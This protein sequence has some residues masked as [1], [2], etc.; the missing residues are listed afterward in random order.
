[1]L[2]N[3]HFIYTLRRVMLFVFSLD[4][5]QTASSDLFFFQKHFLDN[6]AL[7]HFSSCESSFHNHKKKTCIYFMLDCVDNLQE[8]EEDV[9][10]V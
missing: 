3:F 9:L 4:K 8:E 6:Y 1:M 5:R 10:A 7:A 2:I